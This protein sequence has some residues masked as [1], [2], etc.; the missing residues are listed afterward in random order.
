MTKMKDGGLR[1]RGLRVLFI[2]GGAGGGGGGEFV[3][4]DVGE[5]LEGGPVPAPGEEGDGAC[6]G[7]EFVVLGAG[8]EVVAIGGGE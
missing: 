3:E 1:P 7:A 8:G 2:E 6:E 5:V 4:L